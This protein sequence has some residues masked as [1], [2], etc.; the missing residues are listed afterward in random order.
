MMEREVRQRRSAERLLT[1]A[2]QSSREG[3]I[4]IDAAGQIAFANPVALQ[5]FDGVESQG[6]ATREAIFREAL[7]QDGEFRL[8]NGRWLRVSRSAIEEG[9]FIAVC[10]DISV[11]KEQEDQ[12]RETNLRLDAAWTTCPRAC[13]CSMPM[14]GSWW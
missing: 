11:V 7:W 2:L 13:A 10:S 9:G 8:P 3:V 5:F 14:T 1:D 12:L 4:V 6:D